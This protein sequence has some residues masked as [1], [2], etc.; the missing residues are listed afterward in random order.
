MATIVEGDPKAPFSI[1]TAPKCR[2]G[3]YSFLGLL[4]LTLE[5]YLIMLSVKQGGI[6]Y[7]FW[8]FGMTRPRIEPRSP[9]PLANTLTARPMSGN[10]IHI[11]SSISQF[12]SIWPIHKI[13][14]GATTPG[15]HRPGSDGNKWA[16]C[17]CQSSSIIVYYLV[18]YSGPSLWRFS[19]YPSSV[20][21]SVYSAVY[22][23][24]RGVQQVWNRSFFSPKLVTILRLKNS[25]F[26]TIYTWLEREKLDSCISPEY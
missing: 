10:F 4:H 11:N 22:L 12:S 13:L 15:Q 25:L 21:Q 18:L 5:L 1:A 24:L 3:R 20:M 26:F 19:F 9:G 16:V 6:K 8:V 14:S 7:H 23:F 17:I 2:G